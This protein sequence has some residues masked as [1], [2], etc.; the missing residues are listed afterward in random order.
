MTNTFPKSTIFFTGGTGYIGGSVL[1]LML[2]RGYLQAFEIAV[3][4]RQSSDAQR[5]QELGVRPVMGTLDDLDLL[6]HEAA[7][8]DIVFNTANCDH[9]ESAK[10]IIKGL[11]ARSQEAGHPP[12]LIHTSGAGVLTESSNGKGKALKDDPSA[13][14]WDDA[15]F[16]AHAAI[17]SDAPHR[18]VDLEVLAAAQTGLLQICLMVPPTVFGRGLGVFAATRMSIQIPRLVYYSLMQG[19]VLYVGEG[20][21]QWPNVHVADLAELYLLILQAR[22]K[23]KA[24]PG[25]VGLYYPVVEHFTW[26]EV[27]SRIAQLLHEQQLVSSSVA[28]SGLQPGW[29][30]GSNVRM[31]CTNGDKL[32]WKPQH[33]GTQEMLQEVEWDTELVRRMLRSQ[34][35]VLNR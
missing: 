22:L 28:T 33:G 35:E 2:S 15:D 1:H 4:V 12:I 27:A 14:L 8:A 19:R 17:P 25:E 29:F 30:W 16:K 26:L 6:V 21:N 20:I 31:K 34:V 7:R 5:L 10:A 13:L 18:H 9:Q 11:S 23:D 24:L 32:G 3:L